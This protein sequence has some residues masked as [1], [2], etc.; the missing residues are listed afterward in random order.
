MAKTNES[1]QDVVAR[2]PKQG[3]I[4]YIALEILRD[5]PDATAEDIGKVILK[6]FPESKWNKSHLAWYKHQVRSGKIAYP[7]SDGKKKTSSRRSSKKAKKAKDDTTTD[8]ADSTPA[9]TAVG[10]EV[11]A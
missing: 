9:A 4:G 6:S 7:E 3:T 1:K 2:V 5:H 8:N 10:E 11:T